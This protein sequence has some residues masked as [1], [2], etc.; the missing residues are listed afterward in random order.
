MNNTGIVYL[1]YL[2]KSID[3]KLIALQSL[4]VRALLI[5]ISWLVVRVAESGDLFADR[6]QANIKLS[7]FTG[8]LIYLFDYVF[9]L[10]II[11]IEF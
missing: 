8:M 4:L 6:A 11:L 1:L 7:N 2:V 10:L 5:I 3:G 9:F